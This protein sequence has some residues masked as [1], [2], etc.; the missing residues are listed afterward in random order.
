MEQKI[1]EIKK[2]LAGYGI[3]E[4]QNVFYNL[5]YE[6]LYKH[7]FRSD[8]EG[9]E[10]AYLTNT[11]AV[12]VDTGVFT[13]RSPKDK[14][15]VEEG[16]AKDNVWWAQSGRKSSDNKA[17]SPELWEKLYKTASTQLSGKTV[18]VQDSN[19]GANA[20]SRIC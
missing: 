14:Y 10:K 12:T 18:Y 15:I 5:S 8:L 17:I 2:A 6:E 1:Q 11:G 16:S 7:E 19:V 3:T 9:F 20:K 13:G 4:T